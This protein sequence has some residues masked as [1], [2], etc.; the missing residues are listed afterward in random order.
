MKAL[1][2]LSDKQEIFSPCERLCSN[3]NLN[4]VEHEI[5][6]LLKCPLHE[7]YRKELRNIGLYSQ[8][9]LSA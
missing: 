1:L 2:I 7:N 4:V 8:I 3:C 5:H 9:S 6:F